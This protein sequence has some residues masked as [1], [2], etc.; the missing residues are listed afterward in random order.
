MG[1]AEKDDVTVLPTFYLFLCIDLARE[2]DN[3][4]KQKGISERNAWSAGKCRWGET[5]KASF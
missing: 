5:E 1:R 3:G 4:G 2:G